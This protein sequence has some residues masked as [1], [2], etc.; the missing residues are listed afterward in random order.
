MAELE[1]QRLI[2][3]YL[4]GTLTAEEQ[5]QIEERVFT[6]PQF[7]ARVLMIEDELV[8]DYVAGLL[9]ES[10]RERFTTHFLSTPRQIQKLR[11]IR[12]LHTYASADAIATTT[13]PASKKSS[14]VPVRKSRLTALF[15]ERRVISILLAA[16]VLIVVIGAVIYLAVWRRE[17]NQRAAIEQEV[18][19]LNNRQDPRTGLPPGVDLAT[20]VLQ[21]RL[22]P[23]L[24]R[25]SGEMVRISV[26]V[27]AKIV[28]MQPPLTSEPYRSYQAT[29]STVEGNEIFSLASLQPVI[30]EGSY[31]LLLNIPARVLV[32]EDYL[33]KLRGVTQ[34]GKLADPVEY[35]FRIVR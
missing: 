32:H 25:A 15:G 17:A 34:T 21:V 29:L 30:V 20:G 13:L 9:S 12:A 35:P 33:L 14:P 28:Q 22:S 24:N 4:L 5:Q 26:P 10:E 31:A 19:Q 7:K 18:T 8:E 11:I 6:E 2:K 3:A 16:T 27:E 23:A 1:E